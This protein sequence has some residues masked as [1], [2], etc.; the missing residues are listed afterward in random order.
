MCLARKGGSASSSTFSAEGPHP[1]STASA[2]SAHVVA[3]GSVLALA[4][5]LAVQA[6]ASLGASC[7]GESKPDDGLILE[8]TTDQRGIFRFMGILTICNRGI[9]AKR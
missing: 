4:A 3:D 1:T 7:S 8:Q 2:G 9:K 6:K 5:V